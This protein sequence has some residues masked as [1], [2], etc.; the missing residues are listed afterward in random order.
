[1]N[2]KTILILGVSSSIG[3]PLTKK[4]LKQD[5][6]IIGQYNSSNKE[7]LGLKREYK[8]DLVLLKIDF[9]NQKQ[10]SKFLHFIDNDIT[11]IDGLIHLVSPK[12]NIKP[13]MK[14]T[15]EEVNQNLEIQFKSLFLTLKTCIKKL[16][17]S[18]FKR[19]IVINSE[20]ITQKST[21]KGFTAYAIA[22]SAIDQYLNCLNAEF[23]DKNVYI[24]QISP[25][26]FD[27]PLLENIPKYVVEAQQ[28]K[29][30]ISPVNNIIPKILYLLSNEGIE[31]KGQN[32][33][34][35]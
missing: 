28:S 10:I 25:T 33:I 31:S 26:M 34:V 1:M 19:I 7:I 32:F 22:K 35:K 5:Y 2:K 18:D 16:L 6:K 23:S 9:S 13:I 15:W 20:I 14:T 30:S 8:D 17:Q 21:T 11:T 24:N 3:L 29:S 27:S 4:L 12:I